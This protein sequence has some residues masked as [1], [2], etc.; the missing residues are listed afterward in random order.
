[1]VDVGR[2]QISPELLDVRWGGDD[3]TRANNLGDRGIV[4]GIAGEVH[5]RPA[6][7]NRRGPGN[8]A[9]T[10]Y[11]RPVLPSGSVEQRQIAPEHASHGA[12]S[13]HRADIR[14]WITV[15]GYVSRQRTV[16]SILGK[17]PV[18]SN[19]SLPRPA[20]NSRPHD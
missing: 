17:H 20:I 19:S 2:H 11:A 6:V 15:A 13:H 16:L 9:Q 10:V 4:S 7:G 8:L 5:H 1:M 14:C 12:V 3:S 18:I